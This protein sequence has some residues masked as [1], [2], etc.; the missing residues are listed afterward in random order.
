[1]VLLGRPLFLVSCC[2]TRCTA[3]S[4]VWLDAVCSGVAAA[5]VVM[6]LS[7]DIWLLFL[8][9]LKAGWRQVGSLAH[10]KV[11]GVLSVGAGGIGG[12]RW[13]KWEREG[14]KVVFEGIH[15]F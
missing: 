11:G 1:M 3:E 14:Y 2:V 8:L 4:A 12:S 9:R 13:Y 10:G 7:F 15:R 5:V 6:F